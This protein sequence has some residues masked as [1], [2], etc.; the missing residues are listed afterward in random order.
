MHAR[1]DL[2]MCVYVSENLCVSVCVMRACVSVRACACACACVS[3]GL[4]MSVCVSVNACLRVYENAIIL[5]YTIH[6]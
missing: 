3:I 1:V 2:D 5:A 4:C 6:A